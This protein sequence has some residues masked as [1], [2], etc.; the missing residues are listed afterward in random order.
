M[1]V[2]KSI[3]RTPIL[4]CG[5]FLLFSL[6][7]A[8]TFTYVSSFFLVY[9]YV[10]FICLNSMPQRFF[11]D[12]PGIL[13][14]LY[15]RSSL[16]SW[17]WHHLNIFQDRLCIQ[18]WLFIIKGWS[19]VLFWSCNIKVIYYKNQCCPCLLSGYNM[20]FHLA[21]SYSSCNKY[22]TLCDSHYFLRNMRCV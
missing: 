6:L 12:W 13:G 4:I 1:P 8:H 7:F 22:L 9:K 5:R 10:T 2:M 20:L 14:L 18:C 15:L 11:L 21:V 16:D 17:I 19:G 3:W